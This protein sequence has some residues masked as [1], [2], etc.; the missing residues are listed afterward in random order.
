MF[1]VQVPAA[2][3][4]VPAALFVL[5]CGTEALVGCADALGDMPVSHAAE[6]MRV[7]QRS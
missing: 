2:G 1:D 6:A 4:V 3:W 7:E 5:L